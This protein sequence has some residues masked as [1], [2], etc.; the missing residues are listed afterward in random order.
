[1]AV[2]RC[3]IDSM[4]FDAV[5]AEPDL[6]ADVDRLTSARRLELLAAAETMREIGATPDPARRRLLQRVRVLVL[7]P[8]DVR[9][10]A[11]RWVLGD[12]HGSP[13]VSDEDA[14]IAAAAA[15]L[16]V[17]LVTE[18]RDLRQAA[19]THLTHMPLW[20]WEGDLRPRI[21]ALAG[22]HPRGLRAP[23]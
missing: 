2:L 9:D 8:A 15:V 21:T 19:A 10:V 18:D 3:L 6:L 1:M 17:P 20:S 7:P 14:R 11:T 12:L 22:D 4:V 5:V 16:G 23:R 13:G